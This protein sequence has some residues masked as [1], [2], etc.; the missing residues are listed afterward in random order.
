MLNFLKNEFIVG[1]KKLDY[2]FLF[3][4]LGVQV[5]IGIISFDNIL[6]LPSIIVSIL[7]SLAIIFISKGKITAYIL[8]IPKLL[9]QSYVGFQSKVYIDSIESL[10]FLIPI[11]LGL[12][13]WGKN[14]KIT[15]DDGNIISSRSFNPLIWISLFVLMITATIGIGFLGIYVFP[16]IVQ[17]F[18]DAATAIGSIIALLL[19]IFRFREHWIFHLMVNILSFKI[20]LFVGNIPMTIFM[21]ICT[22]NCIYGWILWSKQLKK[23]QLNGIKQTS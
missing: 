18:T 3:L 12:I 1:W 6:L 19:M 5:M 17:P 10:I 21:G 22:L 20:W 23:E 4:L 9:F 7:G 15:E 13:L 8:G 11:I 2:L 14:S 16:D